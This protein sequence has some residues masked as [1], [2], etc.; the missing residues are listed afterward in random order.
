MHP[1]SITD[2][3]QLYFTDDMIEAIVDATNQ[4]AARE[5]GKKWDK[6][7]DAV[8]L[9]AFFGLLLIAGAMKAKHLSY[10]LLWSS[11]YGP[12]IFRATMSLKRFKALL[13]FFAL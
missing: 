7:T 9:K 5:I 4:E 11:S 13:R 10:D 12:P 6:K 1:Q 8:E 2:A 3:F